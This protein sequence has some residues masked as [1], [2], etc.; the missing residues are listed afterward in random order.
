M[1]NRLTLICLLGTSLGLGG[2]SSATYRVMKKGTYEPGV[3]TQKQTPTILSNVAATAPG[4]STAVVV[5]YFGADKAPIVEATGDSSALVQATASAG[6]AAFD[7]GV[8]LA[9]TA[10]T[11]P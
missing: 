3:P 7:I 2:C 9:R 11:G 4:G 10:T 5:V 8:K 1:L 6:R